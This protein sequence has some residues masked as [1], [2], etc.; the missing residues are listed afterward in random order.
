M[1]LKKPGRSKDLEFQPTYILWID[2]NCELERRVKF[3]HSKT[4]RHGTVEVSQSNRTDRKP[5]NSTHYDSANSQ[6]KEN[7]T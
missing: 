3:N 1:M 7:Y 5:C 2:L 6:S 4:D